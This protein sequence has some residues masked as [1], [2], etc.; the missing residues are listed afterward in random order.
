MVSFN[1][2]L[3]V[4]QVNGRGGY[5]TQAEAVA[6]EGGAAPAPAAN[7]TDSFGAAAVD[8][9]GQQTS[10]QFVVPIDEQQHRT[11]MLVRGDAVRADRANTTPYGTPQSAGGTATGYQV[12]TT[13]GNELFAGDRTTIDRLNPDGTLSGYTAHIADGVSTPFSNRGAAVLS[14]DD[15]FAPVSVS[16]VPTGSPQPGTGAGGAGGSGGAGGAGGGVAPP[17]NDGASTSGATGALGQA[18]VMSSVDYSRYDEAGAKI[19]MAEDALM[20]EL[21]RLSGADPFGNQA[22]LRQATDRGVAQASGTASMARGGSAALAGANRGAGFQQQAMQSQGRD[23]MTLQNTQDQIQ[24]GGLRIG[25]AGKVG[26][27]ATAGAENEVEL[28]KLQTE[29]ISNNLSQWIQYQGITQPLRQQDVENMRQIALEYAK[30]DQQKYALDQEYRE[31]VDQMILGRYQADRG[32][33]GILEK[34]KADGEF[35]TKDLVMGFM[36]AGSSVLGGLATTSDRRAKINIYD[37][38]VRDLQDYLGHTKGKFYHYKEPN[39]PGRK[40][41]LNFGGMA[42]DLAKSKIGKT[43]VGTDPDGTLHVKIDRLALAD[44]AA[45]A[46]LAADVQALKTRKT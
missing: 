30:I 23:A 2:E 15:P 13:K 42:Q 10:G 37:P 32:F 27:L 8:P 45:L 41:G 43:V 46:A 18:P 36:G 11:D 31:H 19:K 21:E 22:L 44:H 29:T 33:Q 26:D 38:D 25:A 14:G 20:V 3:G 16:R 5:N 17:M 34:I 9:M 39:K 28:A 1:R 7:N 40:P 35:S 6:A 24:A 12:K 4:W